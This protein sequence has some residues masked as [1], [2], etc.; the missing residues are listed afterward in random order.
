MSYS[1]L[2][3]VSLL[4]RVDFSSPRLFVDS[5]TVPYFIAM[6]RQKKRGRLSS[7]P[8]NFSKSRKERNNHIDDGE[9]P[10][11]TTVDEDHQSTI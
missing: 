10:A 8:N 9:R 4:A 3:F 1:W 5:S 6:E 11:A 7:E 2:Q